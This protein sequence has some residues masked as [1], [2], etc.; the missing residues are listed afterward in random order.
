MTLDNLELI[1]GPRGSVISSVCLINL[2]MV[3]PEHGPWI[4]GD[5]GFDFLKREPESLAAL[6][7]TPYSRAKLRC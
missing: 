1:T 4:T 6:A 7:I 3:L 2:L 5:L